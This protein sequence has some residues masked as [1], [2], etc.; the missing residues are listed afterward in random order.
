MSNEE[1]RLECEEQSDGY[2]DCAYEESRHRYEES[3][4]EYSDCHCGNYKIAYELF[5]E[6]HYYP[7]NG[8]CCDSETATVYVG[9]GE[10]C[11]VYRSLKADRNSNYN[12]KSPVNVIRPRRAER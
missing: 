9:K 7:P 5:N 2:R 4:T 8:S 3:S 6:M 1:T 11:N 10:V 12:D